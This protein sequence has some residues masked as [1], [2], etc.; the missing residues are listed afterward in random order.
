MQSAPEFA[1]TSDAPLP[2][3]PPAEA[4]WIVACLCAAWCR[5]C[6]S[7][8]RAFDAHAAAHPSV[9]FR[10][11]DIEDAADDI[12]DLDVE[13]FPTLLVARDGLPVFFGP[14]LPRTGAIDALLASL[15][16]GPLRA[17]PDA[18]RL[19]DLLAHLAA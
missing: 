9:Q 17:I 13:T 11:V 14:V 1:L 16:G 18:D 8:Q 2:S 10:W 3:D 6:D 12:G 4:R 7:F 5:T 15:A 19:S